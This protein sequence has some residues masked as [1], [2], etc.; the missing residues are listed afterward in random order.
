VQYDG[1]F[2]F[3]YSKRP[4][5]SALKHDGHLPDDIKEKRLARVLD[6]QGEITSRNNEKFVNSIQE[7]LVD[8]LSRKGGTLSGRTRGNK[9]VNFHAP[10]ELIGS[11]TMVRITAAGMNSLT[12]Q[13]C[14]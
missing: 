14:E 9:A 6:L 4:G 10:A 7:V 12:G 11:F 1:I 8:G 3:K 5:T 2:A 13:L